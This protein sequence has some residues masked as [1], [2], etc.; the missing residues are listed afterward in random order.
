MPACVTPVRRVF[1]DCMPCTQTARRAFYD[2]MNGLAHMTAPRFHGRARVHKSATQSARCPQACALT[3]WPAPSSSSRSSRRSRSRHRG[4]RPPLCTRSG[5]L[6]HADGPSA[7]GSRPMPCSLSV[8]VL[9]SRTWTSS[10]TTCLTSPTR[11]RPTMVR[12][13]SYSVAYVVSHSMRS[14]DSTGRPAKSP[15]RLPRRRSLSMSC[16]SGSAPPASSLSVSR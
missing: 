16:T 1:F 12:T 11:T 3:P 14:Q 7:S 5:R 15:R 6:R 4:S 13:L 8:S 2:C 9:R 10:R